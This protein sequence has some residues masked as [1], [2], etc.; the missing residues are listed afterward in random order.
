MELRQLEYFQMASRL[1]SVTKAADCL[2]VAQ[3]S[4]SVAIQKLEEELGVKLFDRNKKHLTLTAEGQI[5]LLHTN[6]ILSRVQHSVMEMNDYRS[7]Q[8]D[9]IRVG[10]T[11]VTGTIFLPH[12]FTKF[13]QAYPNVQVT[14]VEEEFL[15]IRDQLEQGELEIGLV[16]ISNMSPGLETTLITTGQLLVCLPQNHPLGKLASIP[17]SELKDRTFIL[18]KEDPFSRQMILEESNKHQFIPQIIF[19]SSQIETILGLVEQGVGISFLLDTVVSNHS[20]ILKRPLTN[21]LFI[22]AGLAWNKKKYM[23]N[24]LKAFIEFVKKNHNIQ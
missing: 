2:H 3:P 16:N 18:F 23:S 14:I 8:Q 11:P 15:V 21:P 19:S 17:F 9:F 24:A 1:G 7:L 10:M 4:V 13:Q 6:D 20:N 22:Q 5:Y 12:I